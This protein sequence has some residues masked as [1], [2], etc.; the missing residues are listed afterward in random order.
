MLSQRSEPACKPQS[1]RE[2]E[3]QDN[4]GSRASASKP[5]GGSCRKQCRRQTDR[6]PTQ[7]APEHSG[8]NPFGMPAAPTSQGRNGTAVRGTSKVDYLTSS[9]HPRATLKPV[10]VRGHPRREAVKQVEPN[11]ST[12]EGLPYRTHGPSGRAWREY[13]RERRGCRIGTAA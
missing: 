3:C 4:P 11:M 6:S 7:A 10:T 1:Q 2:G 9:A 8:V 5:N 12:S 13:E